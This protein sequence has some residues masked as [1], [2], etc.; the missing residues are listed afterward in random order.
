LARAIDPDTVFAG[1]RE[2][3]ARRT[4]DAG[5]SWVD[6]ALPERRVF[7]LAVS[8]ADGA[9]YAGTEPS[10]LFRSGSVLADI[11]KVERKIASSDMIIVS[12]P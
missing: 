1:L 6:C 8:P 5:T 3:G 9:V 4:V 12:R 7:S 11:T 10:R 2:G